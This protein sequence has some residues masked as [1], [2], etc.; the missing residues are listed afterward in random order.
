MA[1][2]NSAGN[3][4]PGI[5][6]AIERRIGRIRVA[7]MTSELSGRLLSRQAKPEANKYKV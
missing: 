2:L 3:E 6:S 4:D 5:G 1:M 7:A